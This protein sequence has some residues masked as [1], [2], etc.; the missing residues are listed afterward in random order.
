MNPQDYPKS[1][2]APESLTGVV[3]RITYHT[4]QS[5]ATLS[6]EYNPIELDLYVNTIQSTKPFPSE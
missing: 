4:E 1:F 2:Q 5:R 3:E 6:L